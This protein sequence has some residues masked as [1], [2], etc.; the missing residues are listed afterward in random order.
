MVRRDAPQGIGADAGG[1]AALAE[2]L[3][4]VDVRVGRGRAVQVG[5]DIGADDEAAEIQHELVLEQALRRRQ[6]RL[7][8]AG[9]TEQGAGE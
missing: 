2:G 9:G 4:E 5:G 7:R 1:I 8:E 6:L 3:V